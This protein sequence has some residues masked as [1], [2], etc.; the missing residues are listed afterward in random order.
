MK[1]LCVVAVVLAASLAGA[2]EGMWLF[3]AFPSQEV[4]ARYGFEPT[5]AWLDKVRLSAAR[6]AGGCSGSFVSADGL[7]MTNHHCAHS[8]IE[9]LSTAK[10]DLVKDG[11]DAVRP[12]DELRCPEIEVN[13][14]REITDVTETLNAAT[15]GLEGKAF[16]DALKAGMTRLEK[17]CAT[18]DGTRCDVV[19]LYQGGRYHLYRYRRYQD[20]RL[21]FAPEFAIAF[22]GGDPDNF[23]FPRYD[24]DLAFLR[25]YED[26]KPV[27]M[28]AFFPWSAS[29][30]REGELTF[31]AGHPGRTSRS[32][33]VAELAYE[34]DFG[35]PERLFRSSELRGMLTEFQ[36]RGK[37]QARVSN[38]VLFSIEN[39]IKALKGRREALVDAAFF[40]S[41]VKAENELRARV[42]A[43]P[44][45]K[46]QYGQAW[47]GVEGAVK[48]S[49]ALRKP[50]QMLEGGRGFQSDLFT[51]ARTLVRAAA[52]L[53]LPNEKRLREY[54]DARLP[55]LRQQLFSTAPL[56]D[57]FETALLEFSLT[58]LR[59]QL[60]PDDAVVKRV[61]GNDSPA[62]V[63]RRLVR[64][65][66]L[67]DLKVRKALFEGGQ[68]AIAASRDPFIQ[69]A[70]AV[71]PDARAIRKRMED[72]VESVARRNSELVARARFAVYGTSQYPDATFTLRLSYG[73]VQGYAEDGKKVAPLTTFAGA[74]ERH[75][76]SA[77]FALPQRW[78]S[79]KSKLELSTPFNMATTNDIIGGNSGSPVVN[80]DAEIVGLIFD[81]NIQSL[82]GDYGFDPAV[83]R[84][85]SVHGAAILEALEKI[86]GA[87][88]I[89]EEIRGTK[90]A[91]AR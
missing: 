7:V 5:Q 63:A 35:I 52:E 10:R 24:L 75:T 79:A 46:A 18:S 55:G 62:D 3:N 11:F 37:E 14:L 44:A 91:S 23:M 27:K 17:D 20:V 59:E 77:P 12:A 39:G 81:G 71:D 65:T 33:T 89:V 72:E 48:A 43:D 67:K 47:A 85:V 76:G 66:K 70:L 57:G 49:H 1:R 16:N 8:C 61:L 60:G 53:P 28:D 38:S 74:F 40:A 21:V 68:A 30:V 6:L 36:K 31:V 84:A 32:L 51:F 78:L 26:G 56:D 34:R 15:R 58:K 22:F 42:D 90:A 29:G 73:A 13:Q 25:V 41:K 45:L 19:T 83:N 50:Y 9:Q 64:G 80:K 2:D 88:R 54:S 86:Y 82:G 4:K 87:Q 69:L